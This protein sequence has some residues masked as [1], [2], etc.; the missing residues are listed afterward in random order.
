MNDICY[1]IKD[2]V[3]MCSATLRV[4]D[5][6]NYLARRTGMD[7]VDGER[8]SCLV[9]QSPFDYMRQTLV[10]SAGFLPEPD[11]PMY[12]EELASLL[13]SLADAS[14]GRMLVLFTA[15]EM[16]N[17]VAEKARRA[18]DEKGIRLLVQGQG[19]SRNAMARILKTST[20][21][22]PTVLFGA[23]SFWEGV[24]IPGEALSC[25]VLARIPFPQIRE[26]INA[27]RMEY[28]RVQGKSDFREYM[29]P[30]AQ[31]KFRQGVGRLVRKKT[32][33]GVIV[34]A[35][36]R[37]ATKNYG[38]SFRKSVPSPVHVVKERD[39]LVARA[40]EFFQ[41]KKGEWL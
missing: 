21:E 20:A 8:L 14:R 19:V 25:V 13:S 24:D 35:D 23:Q 37:I 17:S 10:M 38:G 39:E 40:A 29:I 26:P 18:F 7:L 32:D 34:L 2:S 28:L 27:A 41:R 30:E 12:G 15:Y 36:Q 31:I 1:R 9:A 5:K 22:T 6:F 11:D 4:G 3:V 16:M 33:E